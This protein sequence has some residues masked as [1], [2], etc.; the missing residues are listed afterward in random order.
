MAGG[1]TQEVK[2]LGAD[3]SEKK[4]FVIG[5]IGPALSEARRKADWLLDGIIKPVFAAH[6]SEFEVTRSDKI[7][8]PGMIDVQMINLLYEAELVIA[9]MTG[10]NANAFYEMGI[11][12][13]IGKPI[14]HMF[15]DGTDIPFDVKPHRAISYSISHPSDLEAAKAVLTANVNEALKPGFQPDN[16]VTRARGV[17]QIKE[18]ATPADQLLLDELIALKAR[19][20]M[21]EQHTWPPQSPMPSTEWLSQLAGSSLA[22]LD[23]SKLNTSKAEIKIEPKA[24]ISDARSTLQQVTDVANK[25]FGTSIVSLADNGQRIAVQPL[26]IVTPN[27]I[28]NFVALLSFPVKS[29]VYESGPL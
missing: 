13:V 28:D 22:R 17:Q 20:N 9:D 4:C 25:I 29:A 7:N 16:P 27:Q 18:H 5:P 6:F 14:I 23:T 24:P 1:E 3:T 15:E 26:Q 8:Q 12:H 2:E 19:I 11:R 10:Q 21:L